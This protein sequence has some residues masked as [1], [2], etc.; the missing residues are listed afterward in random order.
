MHT[1]GYRGR[2]QVRGFQEWERVTV[3]GAPDDCVDLWQITRQQR[4]GMLCNFPS[5]RRRASITER[6]LMS[7]SN[8]VYPPKKKSQSWKGFVHRGFVVLREGR[9]FV[10]TMKR[11]T[12]RGGSLR[13]HAR[14]SKRTLR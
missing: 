7:E 11:A 8:G 2:Q 9:A 14:G 4:K 1:L 10:S 5:N 3:S 12:K 13:V 6:K